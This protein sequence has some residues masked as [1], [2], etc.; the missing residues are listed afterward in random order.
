MK[1]IILD[2]ETTGLEPSQGH[3]IIEIAAIEMINRHKT[4]RHFHQYLKPDCEIDDGAFSVHG[5]SNEFLADKPL[6][7]EIAQDLLDFIQGSE[8]IIHNA[9]FDIGFL[10]A[11][12]K[13]FNEQWSKIEDHCTVL[14]TLSLAREKHPGLKNNLDELCK[15]YRVDNSQRNLHG[16]LLDSQLLAD[17]YLAMTSEQYDLHLFDESPTP[18]TTHT[19]ISNTPIAERQPLPIMKPSDEELAAHQ[20][21]LARIKKESGKCLWHDL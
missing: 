19:T 14:D 10:N 17:V 9:P 12:F 16:A 20:T 5:L 4:E 1:Q 7:A 8:L 11:E 6:F 21:Q 2:T 3:R 13:M 15:R 18:Q